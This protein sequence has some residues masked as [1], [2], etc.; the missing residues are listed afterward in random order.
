MKKLY[1]SKEIIKMMKKDGWE[2]VTVRG[3]HNQ[4][5]HPVKKGKVTVVHPQERMAPKAIHAIFKQAGLKEE[6]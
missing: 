4:F 3:D 5:K 2:L 1:S 6:W